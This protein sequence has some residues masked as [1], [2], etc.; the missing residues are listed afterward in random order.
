MTPK[1]RLRVLCGASLLLLLNK[2]ALCSFLILDDVD[3]L[4][5]VYDDCD[6]MFVGIESPFIAPPTHWH[7]DY[8]YTLFQRPNYGTIPLP[9]SSQR[10][11]SCAFAISPNPAFDEDVKMLYES[12]FTDWRIFLL[13]RTIVSSS[14]FSIIDISAFITGL[15]TRQKSKAGSLILKLNL[16]TDDG[17]GDITPLKSLL[18]KGALC[19]VALLTV[20]FN[21]EVVCDNCGSLAC[22]SQIFDVTMS[23]KPMDDCRISWLAVDST[24]GAYSTT[25]KQIKNSCAVGKL[26]KRG[27][28]KV[29][30]SLSS[31]VLEE[32]RREAI[33]QDLVDK[34]TLSTKTIEKEKD[35][36]IGKSSISPSES[37]KAFQFDQLT[38]DLEE[39]KD[40]FVGASN[41]A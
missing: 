13:R 21:K 24:G 22:L 38:S 18:V 14:R 23:Y 35:D 29:S 15:S 8:T 41:K 12:V 11:G 34:H 10:Q 2:S 30:P 9:L 26:S 32:G 19:E 20:D 3:S 36:T 28:P 39:M 16:A 17:K 5:N 4:E 25:C 40:L 31:T 27:L 1:M 37:S 33:G 6:H 7:S